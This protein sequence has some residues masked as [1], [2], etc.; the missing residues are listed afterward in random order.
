MFVTS[1]RHIPVK[2]TLDLST[3]VFCGCD[4]I[5]LYSVLFCVVRAVHKFDFGLI[6]KKTPKKWRPVFFKTLRHVVIE[7]DVFDRTCK[8]SPDSR[9]EC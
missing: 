1:N 8:F 6:M 4:I 7:T 3:V 5:H 2:N 9:R